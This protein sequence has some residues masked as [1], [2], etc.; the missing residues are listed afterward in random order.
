MPESFNRFVAE[1]GVEPTFCILSSRVIWKLFILA[2]FFSI[3]NLNLIGL[4]AVDASTT[5]AEMNS[6]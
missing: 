3:F 5:A 1:L 4:P 2:L 6:L